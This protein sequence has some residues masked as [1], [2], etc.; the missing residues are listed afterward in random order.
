LNLIEELTAYIK[1]KYEIEPEHPWMKYP[2]NR[3]FKEPLSGKWFALI[4]P[5]SK[6]NL[7]ILEAGEIYVVNVKS[8]PDFIGMISQTDGYMPGYHMNKRHWL[9]IFL[10]GTVPKEQIF[11]RIDE[12]YARITDS[13]SRRIYEAVKKI[14]KGKV[15][16]YGQVAELAGDRKMARAVGNALHKNPDPDGIPCYRVV[17]AKGELAGEFAFGGAGAQARL[18]EADGIEVRNGKVDLKKFGI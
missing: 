3:T 15:A 8:D 7:G 18:L 11:D 2:E 12:S 9:T 6:R 5:V 1:E 13:P 10:D 14:P 4:M 16:T 17:N